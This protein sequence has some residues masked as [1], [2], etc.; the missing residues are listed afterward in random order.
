MK[1]QVERI[2][3]LEAKIDEILKRQ[4]KMEQELSKYKGFIGGIS[5]VVSCVIVFMTFGKDWLLS[6]WK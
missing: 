6:H 3:R 1:E 2:D 4:G 5:F